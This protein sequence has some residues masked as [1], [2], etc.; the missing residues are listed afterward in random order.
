M[1][2]LSLDLVR[3]H[4]NLLFVLDSTDQNNNMPNCV[5]ILADASDAKIN[6]LTLNPRLANA[7]YI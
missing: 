6:C 4:A 3:T 2:E 1:L 5:S 7:C